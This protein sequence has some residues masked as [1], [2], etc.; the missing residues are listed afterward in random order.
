MMTIFSVTG[1]L[2]YVDPSGAPTG[3]DGVFRRLERACAPFS[4]C[5]LGADYADQFVR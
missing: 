5:D 4:A 1:A 3:Y 2:I